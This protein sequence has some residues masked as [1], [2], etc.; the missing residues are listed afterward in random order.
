MTFGKLIAAMATAGALT[1]CGSVDTASRNASFAAPVAGAPVAGDQMALAA[2]SISVARI[3]VTVPQS[4]K[5]SEA[6]RYYPQGDIVWRE[7]PLGDRHQQVQKIFADAMAF[8][9]A[10]FQGSTP[11][12]LDIEVERFHALTEK[13]R[14]T[15]GG[16]HSLRF[17]LTVRDAASGALLAEPRVVKA[18]L[19][20]FGGQMAKDAEARGETQKV[21]ISGHLAQVIRQELTAPTGHKNAKLGLFQRIN[22]I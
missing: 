16:V 20:A 7:D 11:V 18:D 17:K 21:R 5:V 12:V 15:V 10:D 14:Y 8:G 9:T 4:L 22:N 13:A 19:D 2:P 3:N 1:A 6:N